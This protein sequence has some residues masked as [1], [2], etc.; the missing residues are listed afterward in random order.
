MNVALLTGSETLTTAEASEIIEGSN[1]K[2]FSVTFYKKGDKSGKEKNEIRVM[3]A[4]LGENTR[5]GLAGGP[6]AYKPSAHGLVWVYLMAGDC[7]RAEEKNRRS[8]SVGGIVRLAIDGKEF[9]VAGQ[10]WP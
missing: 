6:A 9:R 7:N 8:V 1:G 3:R 10:P 2:I 5:K 4:M